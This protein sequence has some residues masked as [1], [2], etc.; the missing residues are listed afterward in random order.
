[1]QNS[2]ELP[3]PPNWLNVN[4]LVQHAH[5]HLLET[6]FPSVLIVDDLAILLEL[7]VYFFAIDHL[8]KKIE[9]TAAGGSIKVH[10]PKFELVESTNLDERFAVGDVCPSVAYIHRLT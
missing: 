1:M 10:R 9:T 5:H 2:Q 4:R 8:L 6:E 3:D 7:P